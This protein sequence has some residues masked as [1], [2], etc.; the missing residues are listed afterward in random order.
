MTSE[1]WKTV[2]LALIAAVV[3]LGGPVIAFQLAKVTTQQKEVKQAVDEMHVIVNGS[4]TAMKAQLQAMNE[5]LIASAESNAGL[6]EAARNLSE[7]VKISAARAETPPRTQ[8]QRLT[9]R[10]EPAKPLPVEIVSTAHPLPVVISE[11][12]EEEGRR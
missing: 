12:E 4:E 3:T 6:I 7:Q 1:D 5:R 10:I 8:N 9:D 11:E 2:L